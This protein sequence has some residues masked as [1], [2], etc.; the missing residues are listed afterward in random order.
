MNIKESLRLQNVEESSTLAMAALAREYKSKGIDVISLSL[1]EP[2][3]KTPP[4]ICDG[5]KDAIDSGNYFSYPPVPGYLDLREAIS[6]KFKNENNLE[7][8]QNQILVSAGCKQS[9]YNLCQAILDEGDEVLIPS[10][11]WVSYPEIVKLSDA[12]P[13]FIETNSENNFKVRNNFSLDTND[14]DISLARGLN[15]EDGAATL[16]VFSAKIISSK[17]NLLLKEFNKEKINIIICG[18][19]RK[20]Y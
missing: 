17:I 2:D 11:Y 1:G 5:A 6:Q 19:G 9:I 13:V 10:P 20:N 16:T 7:Y 15:L 12:T 4:H 3:F 8:K 14:F 18:G